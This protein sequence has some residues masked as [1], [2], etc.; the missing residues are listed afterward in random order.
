[1]DIDSI[2]QSPGRLSTESSCSE[3]GRDQGAGVCKCTCFTLVGL[4]PAWQNLVLLDLAV[5]HYL[6]D[7]TGSLW[8]GE[9]ISVP[10]LVHFVQL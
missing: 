4:Q 8:P 2:A 6:R 7:Q 3:Q 5:A 9:D 1:M 10:L